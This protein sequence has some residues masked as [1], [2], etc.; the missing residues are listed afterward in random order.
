MELLILWCRGLHTIRGGSY[1]KSIIVL[2]PLTYNTR[3]LDEAVAKERVQHWSICGL[4][5]YKVYEVFGIGMLI[6][7]HKWKL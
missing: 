6:V 2:T 5:L 3:T 1:R 7:L 4:K